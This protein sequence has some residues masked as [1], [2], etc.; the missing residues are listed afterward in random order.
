[1]QGLWKAKL[2]QESLDLSFLF[3]IIFKLLVN[4]LLQLLLDLDLHSA[5]LRRDNMAELILNR[6]FT[7]K[8]VHESLELNKVLSSRWY[9]LFNR[10]FFLEIDG[11]VFVDSLIPKFNHIGIFCV[12][13]ILVARWDLRYDWL[14]SLKLCCSLLEVPNDLSHTLRF[15]VCLLQ[16]ILSH[17]K[18]S[19]CTKVNGMILH[20]IRKFATIISLQ[21]LISLAQFVSFLKIFGDLHRNFSQNIRFHASLQSLSVEKILSLPQHQIR[22]HAQ[23]LTCEIARNLRW[24]KIRDKSTKVLKSPCGLLEKFACFLDA[25][26]AKV[27]VTC[28]TRAGDSVVIQGGYRIKSWLSRLLLHFIE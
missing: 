3:L 8:V 21:S 15:F 4:H 26:S 11:L 17:D 5:N 19:H 25:V 23:A 1:M 20:D 16:L 24:V 14:R 12:K 6:K 28:D 13:I 22:K 18:V 10:G 7:L 27:H 2:L 9:N